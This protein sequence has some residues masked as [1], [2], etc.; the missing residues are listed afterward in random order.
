MRKYLEWRQCERE[1]E[2]ALHAIGA[3]ALG[4]RL[5]RSECGSHPFP[6]PLP[7]PPHPAPTLP[8]W[9]ALAQKLPAR[10][11]RHVPALVS[12]AGSGR[13]PQRLRLGLRAARC[14]PARRAA[15][16]RPRLGRGPWVGAGAGPWYEAGRRAEGR[17]P[18]AAPCGPR[19]RVADSKRAAA[20]SGAAPRPV[21]SAHPGAAPRQALRQS[22]RQQPRPPAQDQGAATGGVGGWGPSAPPPAS[23]GNETPWWSPLGASGPHPGWLDAHDRL[24]RK[25]SRFPTS[26]PWLDALGGLP[27]LGRR[28]PPASEPPLPPCVPSEHTPHG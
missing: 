23:P 12:R 22:H 8:S 1:K 9:P 11:R 5:L 20:A 10:W 24:P 28:S 15:E 14:P 16:A 7:S 25:T 21:V 3:L 27:K 13:D 17:V 6:S 18:C 4:P 26:W 19:P 2:E